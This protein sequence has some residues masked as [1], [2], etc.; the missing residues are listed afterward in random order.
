MKVLVVGAGGREHALIWKIDRSSLVK[1]IYCAPGS[2]GTSRLAR[3]VPIPPKSVSELAAFAESNRIDLTVVGPELPLNL[4]I[5]DEFTR[6]GLVIF[7]AR[8]GAAE[9]ETS[10]I[11]AKE[12]MV[13]NR[14]PTAGFSVH[15]DPDSARD[16]IES[17]REFPVV[18]KADG[19]AAGKG[20]IIAADRD[21]AIAAIRTI[22]EEK[23][24]GP[25][26]DRVLIEDY[27]RGREASMFAL[28]DGERILP[29]ATCRDYKAVFDGDRGPNTG[30][31]GSYTPAPR[32]EPELRRQ[33]EAEVLHP[34]VAGM[35]KEGREYRGILYAGVMLTEAG[36]QVL[37][38]N[39]RFGDPETQVLMPHMESD[40]VP[41]LIECASGSLAGKQVAWNPGGAVCVVLASGGYPEKPDTGIPIH[42]LEKL[43]GRDDLVLFHAGTK[44]DADGTVRTGGGRVLNI[45]GVGTDLPSA[46]R[47]AYA[48][49]DRVRFDGMHFRRDIA[50]E[51]D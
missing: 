44:Q 24:F 28:T 35:A 8:R 6:R 46:R 43:E 3:P 50:A 15:D 36:P 14:I 39:A 23:K 47:I 13:R 12:F 17:R 33:I 27:L 5:A 40:L 29:L 51:A 19:L 2:P 11:F 4:G 16:A 32:P 34:A 45:V 30:G 26:G 9:I 20:V 37:E 42:G 18:I 22:M 10:K 7:G 48:G 25:A 1:E 31:M 49:A 41:L 21:A 38:F